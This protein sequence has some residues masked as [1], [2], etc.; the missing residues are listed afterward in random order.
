MPDDA[1]GLKVVW[2]DGH[3]EPKMPPDPRFPNGIDMDL[4]MAGPARDTY[5]MG[6]PKTCT[7]AVPYP[8]KRVGYYIITCELCDQ[9]IVVTTAGRPDDPR[10]VKIKCK[11]IPKKETL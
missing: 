4:S 8:A 7:T 3:R 2:F 11:P 6:A 10:S 1:S 5:E 9:R